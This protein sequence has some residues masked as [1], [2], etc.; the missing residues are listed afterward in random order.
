MFTTT[1]VGAGLVDD[2]ICW[3][4]RGVER[5]TRWK[6]RMIAVKLPPSDGANGFHRSRPADDLDI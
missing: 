4:R 5:Q 1:P 6:T 3:L 2:V